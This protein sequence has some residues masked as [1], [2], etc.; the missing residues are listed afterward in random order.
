LSIFLRIFQLMMK[1]TSLI[2][3]VAYSGFLL[4]LL[5]LFYFLG[6]VDPSLMYYWQQSIPL[7][8]G[9]SIQAPGGLSNLLG[10]LLLESLTKPVGGSIAIT[11]ILCVILLSYRVIFRQQKNLFTGFA[12]ILAAL[13]PVILLFA[14]YQFPAGLIASAVSGLILSAVHSLH[15]P[16]KF[17]LRSVY[18]FI[19]AIGVYLVS[20]VA[21][22]LIFFQVIII[23]S[24]KFKDVTAALPL[25]IVPL[26]FL[27]FDLSMNIRTAYL[28]SFLISEYNILP[29]V[30]YLCLFSPLFL[31]AGFSGLNFI[32]S[33]QSV[34]RRFTVKNPLLIS[35]ISIAVV[36]AV[37]VLSS[38]TSFNEREKDAFALV[39]AGLQND[40][41]TVIDLAGSQAMLTQLEQFEFNRALYHS[42]QFLDKL[43]QHPQ[44][45]GEKGL[46][47]EEDISC[48][49]AIHM[50]TFN[51]DLGFA[52]ETRH[53]ATE[54]QMA[55][56]RHP[57]V[58]KNLV[59]SYLAMGKNEAAVKYLHVLSGSRLHR[60]WSEQI[61]G[62][63]ENNSSRDDARV[64]AF[65][66]NNPEVNFFCSTSD[67][68]RKLLDFYNCNTNN[69]MAF[70]YLIAS[71][72]MQH[73]VGKVA[74]YLSQFTELGYSNLP[75]AVEEAMLIY[76]TSPKADLNK[77]SGFTASPETVRDFRELSGLMAGK[78]E[79]SVK[80][81][82][83]AKFK[84]TY[85]YYILFTSP[86][87]T[88]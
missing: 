38:G 32:S 39:R 73:E 29:P 85:W 36:I 64:Q 81:Q 37:L 35:G 82:K 55:F 41:E 20:G 28:G 13:I 23:L 63:I 2:K 5:Y 26:L 30:Y 84:N 4:I 56:M 58:L 31:M 76:A 60:E 72:L 75:R 62:L 59:I 49:V 79:R 52:N 7:S 22:L 86:N 18:N 83:A 74:G 11:L 78:G 57:V 67:P 17:L 68:T 24:A 66:K 70:E 33:R 9:E 80:M 77:V 48:P 25:L 1:K 61:H 12:L 53:W 10:D 16:G 27:P 44:P 47:L 3:I 65:I 46:F 87:A 71:Y 8:F 19:I 21:G 14:H 34:S 45:W 88:K 50:S 69:R 51:M 43:F 6:K 40:V 15:T 54:A 42:G